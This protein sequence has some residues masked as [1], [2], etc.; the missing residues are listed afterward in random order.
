[1][2]NYEFETFD[3]PSDPPPESAA[4]SLNPPLLNH[5][6]NN[7]IQD[8]FTQQANPNSGMH[9][10][11]GGYDG[12]PTQNQEGLLQQIS[13]G[14]LQQHYH[15]LL[16][17]SPPTL[18]GAHA[19]P[20]LQYH[21]PLIDPYGHNYDMSNID[22]SAFNNDDNPTG[23]SQQQELFV[24]ASIL[25]NSASGQP[26]QIQQLQQLPLANM[27]DFS[28][29]MGFTP[30]VMQSV[31][32][33][34][35]LNSVADPPFSDPFASRP[36]P[37]AHPQIV[38]DRQER[39]RQEVLQT[40]QGRASLSNLSMLN[41]D[42]DFTPDPTPMTAPAR[43]TGSGET[44]GRLYR[45]GSDNMFG[46]DRFRP[47]FA[48]ENDEVVSNRLTQ[49]L[50]ML[51]PINRSN[52]N[53]RP[54]TPVELSQGQ[55]IGYQSSID[56]QNLDENPDGNSSRKRR[57]TS[58]DSGS[59]AGLSNPYGFPPNSRARRV[60][61]VGEGSGKRRKSSVAGS[62]VRHSRE[63]LSDAQ[64]RTNHIQSEQKRRDLIKNGFSSL[65]YLV[66]ELRSGGVSKSAVLIEAA[67]YLEQLMAVNKRMKDI[68]S[69]NPGG[70]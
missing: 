56:G 40:P 17:E 27:H 33:M 50:H 21:S 28:Q 70:G 30:N 25:N 7:Y 63:N 46:A 18:I 66:P 13:G 32:P 61:S 42:T 68:L 38:I 16:D 52:N 39:A 53:T 9:D 8:F 58:T 4:P 62:M 29:T 55:Q 2:F 60:P 6:E 19:A 64:K 35:N 36:V 10:F 51:K 34:R 49:E 69:P 65:Q 31:D 54:P 67:N 12:V 48:S 43:M 3:R 24:A 22:F 57:K 59:N 20:S 47:A 37:V 45:F 26:P 14:A 11:G 1:M 41:T 44:M 5:D 23:A 15:F